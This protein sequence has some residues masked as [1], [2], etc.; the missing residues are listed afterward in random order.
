MD[1]AM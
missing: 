1:K